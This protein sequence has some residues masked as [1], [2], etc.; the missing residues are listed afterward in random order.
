MWVDKAWIGSLPSDTTVAFLFIFIYVYSIHMH[1]CIHACVDTFT[2]YI[3]YILKVYIYTLYIYI[4]TIF[5]SV[6]YAHTHM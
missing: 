1:T 4:H 5:I 3:C 6:I 2:I